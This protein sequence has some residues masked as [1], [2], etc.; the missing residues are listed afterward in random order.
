ML[1]E[2]IGRPSKVLDSTAKEIDIGS[3]Q[4]GPTANPTGPRPGA[5]TG[6]LGKRSGASDQ[7]SVPALLGPAAVAV[8]PRGRASSK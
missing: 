6:G 5:E 2:E 1:V 3:R 8:G 4:L 7:K